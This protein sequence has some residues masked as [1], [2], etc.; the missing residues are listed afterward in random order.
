MRALY[1]QRFRRLKTRPFRSQNDLRFKAKWFAQLAKW[2]ARHFE[3]EGRAWENDLR[4]D[5]RLGLRADLRY[6]DGRMEGWKD[7]G[8][9][10]A[11]QIISAVARVAPPHRPFYAPAAPSRPPIRNALPPFCTH[12]KACTAGLTCLR[13]WRAEP[14][15]P[16]DRVGSLPR[17]A[18]ALA[19]GA[20]SLPETA[21]RVG[22]RSG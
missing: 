14:V 3:C 22:G 13:C 2:S 7:G 18:C 10:S 4:V 16:A 11:A 9:C 19:G 6:K 21:L 8:A 12:E 20:G 5:L 17:T 1:R 15:P